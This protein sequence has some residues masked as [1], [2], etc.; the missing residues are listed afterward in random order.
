MLYDIDNL[1]KAISSLQA[2]RSPLNSEILL[3]A[4]VRLAFFSSIYF[5][6]LLLAYYDSLLNCSYLEVLPYKRSI[7][8]NDLLI[9]Y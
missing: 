8:S 9:L 6:C 1:I 4:Y 2:F 5:F 7:F 3:F